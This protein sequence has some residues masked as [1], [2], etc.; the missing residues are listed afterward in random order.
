[1]TDKAA[2]RALVVGSGFG[3]R[4]H[5]PAL[6]AVGFEVAGL[7]GRDPD[8]TQ[9]RAEANGIARWFTDLGEAI[10][11]T[12]AVAVTI[13]STPHSH[14]A[15]T[16]TAIEHG[17]HVICEKPMAATAQEGRAM[18]A[19]AE[20]AGVTHLMGNEFRWLPDRALVMR[21]IADGLIG[22]PRYATLSSYSAL[23]ADPEAKMPRWWF[24]QGEGGGWLGAQGS[25]II[26]QM[27]SWLGD[28]ESLSASLPT[29][30]AREGGAE[31][32]YTVKFRL[33]NGVE[34]VIQQSA[35]AWGPMSAMTR[36]AGTEGTLWVENGV[37]KLAT[38]EGVRDL[39]VTDDLAL[40]PPPDASDDPR[41]R[42][43]Q[44]ELGPYIRL[45]EVLRAGVDGRD[46]TP[47]VPAPTFRDGVAAMEVMDAV[48][49][50]AAEG[51]TLVTL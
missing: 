21:A 12:G 45:C 28:F 26:D 30:S 3:C 15:L 50:S 42:F 41:K 18:L 36:V 8:R 35:G 27:R 23:V 11:E 19:A 40:P 39:P 20:A 22:E 29:V 1:M 17:C 37:V 32:S 13:A 16:L 38:K 48:R 43:S 46:F 51:G 4:I 31:D 6:R 25:H 33:K 5:V 2:P 10:R 9:R 24:D 7:V 14:A 49:R 47:A 34:G 44:F